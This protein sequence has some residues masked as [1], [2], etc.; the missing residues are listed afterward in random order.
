[1]F[2]VRILSAL[3]LV[4]QATQCWVVELEVS[5]PDYL[6]GGWAFMHEDFIEL[7]FEK[8]ST[9]A[10]P[11][12]LSGVPIRVKEDNNLLL[13]M[14]DYAGVPLYYLEDFVRRALKRC[15][16]GFSSV[17]PVESAGEVV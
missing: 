10:P 5:S 13:D 11:A 12:F 4:E 17:C 15:T 8:K 16:F 1:M 9:G 7:V 3:G 6:I 14:A 2:S